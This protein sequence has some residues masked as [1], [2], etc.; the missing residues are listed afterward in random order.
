MLRQCNLLESMVWRL[1]L[2]GLLNLEKTQRGIKD[3]VGVPR[4]A[5]ARL[6]NRFH[7]RW[8]GEHRQGQGWPM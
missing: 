8:N 5:D 1:L 4:S 6:C 2:S 7:N 3:D